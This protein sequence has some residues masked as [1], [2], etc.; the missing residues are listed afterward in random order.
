MQN[1]RIANTTPLNSL[2]KSL[3][4]IRMERISDFSIGINLDESHDGGAIPVGGEAIR[5]L[6]DQTF[7]IASSIPE[8]GAT[9]RLV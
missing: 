6:T 8:P 1:L 2:H 4:N 7:R 5:Q 9:W 3:R